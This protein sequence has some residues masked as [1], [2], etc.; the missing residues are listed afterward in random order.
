MARL[1]ERFARS[2]GFE[3]A[4]Q[5]EKLARE[6][7][8][9]NAELHS[10]HSRLAQRELELAQTPNWLASWSGSAG[11]LNQD[12]ASG[13]KTA[14]SRSRLAAR[15]NDYARKFLGMC[16]DNIVGP[17]GIGMQ[18][19]VT[20]RDGSLDERYNVPLEGAFFAWGKKGTCDV[21]ARYSWRDVQNLCITHIA[22]D[23]EVLLRHVRNR[24]PHGYQVQLI[25]PALLDVDY[26]VD[27]PNGRKVRLGVEIDAEGRPLAYWVRTDSGWA[28]DQQSE[29]YTKRERIPAD[30][31]IHAFIPEE[32]NQLRGLPWMNSA[33]ARLHQVRDYED[34]ALVA[35]RNAAKRVGF[36]TSAD[37]NP[38][39]GMAADDGAGGYTPTVAGQFDTL[40]KGY[41]FTPFQ[42][43]YPHTNF[44]DFTKSCLRGAAS[45]LGV[46]YVT[47]GNDLEAVNFSS[48]RVGIVGE[49][50]LWKALQQW[51]ID[52]LCAPVYAEW[53][54]YAAL[55]VPALSGR[56][57]YDKVPAFADAA[58]WQGRRWSGI[59]PLKEANANEVELSLGL[60][61]RRRILIEKGLDPEEVWRELEA[62]NERLAGVL[63]QKASAP[64]APTEET[65][66][67][68]DADPEQ[69]AA[70]KAAR[71]RVVRARAME[72]NQ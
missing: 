67:Q 58:V 26:R 12:L 3:P 72:W 2:L 66:D 41:E 10:V 4:P 62:E 19:H 8:R 24:G 57:P 47:F 61:S 13:L 68:E 31:V 59:D 23:G 32:I 43:E 51:V 1:L 71:L 48:A 29:L 37:G 38:I 45:G 20:R 52:T 60:T 21:T 55:T 18:S 39:P 28:N 35:S 22:R 25:D 65:P 69:A 14:R 44:G 36:F 53:L 5:V 40:P 46:S 63:P 30:E 64:A 7:G 6:T 34:A 56:I 49:R 54:R 50:E 70:E 15:N 33:L 9:L 17:T 42:S 16:R 27:L 11:H